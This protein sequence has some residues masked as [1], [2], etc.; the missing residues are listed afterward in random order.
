MEYRQL[1]KLESTYVKALP[2]LINP[3]T[4]RLHSSFNQTVAS[5]GRLSSSNPNLQNIPI[6]TDQGKEIRNSFTIDRED[7]VILAADYSQIELR[8]LAFLSE[9]PSLIEAFRK[10]MDIHRQTAA[11]IYEKDLED[12]TSDERRYAK[13]I[14][15]GL[16]YGM[17]AFRISNELNISRKEAQ[18]FVDNY[19]NKFPTIKG[20]LDGVIE[21]ARTNGYVSTIFGRKLYLPEIN[22]KNKLRAREAERVATNMP[23]QGSAA[24]IIKLAM[25]NINNVI[26]RRNDIKMIIQVHDELVFEIQKD[27]LEEAREI[28]VRE[29]EAALPENYSKIVPLTVDI[30]IGRNWFEAH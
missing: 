20:Y 15:F 11:I 19:F 22:S 3:N 18:E 24:D 28:I 30:G 5:T 6:R 7:S 29:M 9:D 4:G 1:N 2:E 17:G 14:N 12:V 16:L 21:S 10:G 26:R 13:I 27:N 25:I 8:I 23:I